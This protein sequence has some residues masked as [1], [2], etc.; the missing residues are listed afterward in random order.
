MKKYIYTLVLVLSGVMNLSAREVNVGNLNLMKLFTE[1]YEKM[2]KEDHKPSEAFMTVYKGLEE[3][4]TEFD[5]ELF[6]KASQD[7][8][9]LIPKTLFPQ[10]PA[11]K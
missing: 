7:L 2:T 11:T 1:A 4:K 6:C 5:Y 8:S 3:G 10:L 9:V